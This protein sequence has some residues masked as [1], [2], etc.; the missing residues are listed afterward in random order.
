M[1]VC[2]FVYFIYS[3]QI[4]LRIGVF[5]MTFQATLILQLSYLMYW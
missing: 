4:S 1:F 2:L 5:T 3:G